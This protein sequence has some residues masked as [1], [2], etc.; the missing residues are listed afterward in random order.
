MNW[1]DAYKKQQAFK[2]NWA[3]KMYQVENPYFSSSPLPV[4]KERN[5]ILVTSVSG[6]NTVVGTGELLVGKKECEE[7]S[8]E[9]RSDRKLLK[10][11]YLDI[12]VFLSLTK[13]LL[14]L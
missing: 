11:N 6:R 5:N 1:N 12:S 2:H 14:F 4:Y 10:K 7:N 13:L 8:R 3:S 9:G